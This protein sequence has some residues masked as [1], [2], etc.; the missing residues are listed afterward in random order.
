MA[1]EPSKIV[2]EVNEIHSPSRLFKHLGEAIGA[3]FEQGLSNLYTFLDQIPFGVIVKELLLETASA[4][5]GFVQK[6][7]KHVREL[8]ENIGKLGTVFIGLTSAFPII[9][10]FVVSSVQASINLENINRKLDFATGSKKASEE[11]LHNAKELKL[12]ISDALDSAG[13]FSA[14]LEG[15]P[16]QGKV[17]QDVFKNFQKYFAARGGTQ[18]QQQR[19]SLQLEQIAAIGQIQ[20]TDLRPL[21]QAVPGIQGVLA[22][23][24]GINPDELRNRLTTGGGLGTDAV[25][26][27]SQQA[28]IEAQAGLSSSLDTTLAAST[29]LTNSIT[30]LQ[31]ALGDAFKPVYKV[32][33]NT[34]ASI[35][36]F[37]GEHSHVVVNEMFAFVVLKIAIDKY[38]N[39]KVVERDAI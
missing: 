33:L 13:E 39:R 7:N 32:Y 24:Q 5:Q 25:V 27:F 34:L 17:G 18:D 11:V 12:N 14:A 36:D 29:N 6:S 1:T 31:A 2:K 21:S 15:T 23:S 8:V 20:W 3:G 26:K 10:D 37:L 9:R 19:A 22:R 38:I 30:L 4:I 16:I 35:M 28:A